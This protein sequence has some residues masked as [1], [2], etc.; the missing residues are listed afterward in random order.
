MQTDR[1]NLICA[2]DSP[3]YSRGPG[4][5]AAGDRDQVE[6]T[7]A[8][9]EV[10]ATRR[11]DSA[12][13]S[14]ASRMHLFDRDRHRSVVAGFLELALYLFGELRGALAGSLQ[15]ASPRI[16]YRSIRKHRDRLVKVRMAQ[17]NDLDD[18]VWAKDVG[19]VRF[20]VGACRPNCNE[21]EGECNHYSSKEHFCYDSLPDNGAK[22]VSS[23]EKHA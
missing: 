13:D 16:R 10:I 12:D 6:Q 3:G 2:D 4:G 21:C 23:A 7:P 22:S 17:H 18:V 20:V 11:F 14:C 1:H 15:A 9:L 8:R 19:R 5:E